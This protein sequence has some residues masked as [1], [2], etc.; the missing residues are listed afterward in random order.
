MAADKIFDERFKVFV[1]QIIEGQ[2][3]RV[4]MWRRLSDRAV[5]HGF[6]V[7]LLPC[8]LGDRETD[9]IRLTPPVRELA[10]DMYLLVRSDIRKL[11]PVYE[12]TSNLVRFFK[13]ND[14]AFSGAIRA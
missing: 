5:K 3:G 2:L 13:E 8:V 11:A 4:G 1:R 14:R 9:L 10:E 6:G 7:S 12:I